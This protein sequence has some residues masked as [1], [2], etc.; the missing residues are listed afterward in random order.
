M[1][2]GFH[3]LLVLL[4][5]HLFRASLANLL[6]LLLFLL[7]RLLTREHL[8]LIAHQ[9][10]EDALVESNLEKVGKRDWLHVASTLLDE[11]RRHV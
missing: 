11:L 9:G 3:A 1:A 2:K 5:F 7:E 8:L 4:L 10:N 6:A